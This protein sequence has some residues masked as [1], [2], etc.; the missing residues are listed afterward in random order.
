[1]HPNPLD[2][3]L[4]QEL[5]AASFGLRWHNVEM[6]LDQVRDECR[7]VRETIAQNEGK[8]RLQ[9]EVGDLIHAALTV[10][11]LLDL[12]IHET[13]VKANAKFASRLEKVKKVAYSLG[14]SSL[15]GQSSEEI[16]AIWHK[17]KAWKDETILA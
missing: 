10:C 8:E 3:L 1:M 2:I 13:L 6:L 4:N 14:F 15:K 9:E 16:M 12:D 11:I 7:E 5:D 17:A